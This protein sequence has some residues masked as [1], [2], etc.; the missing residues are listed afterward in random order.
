MSQSVPNYFLFSLYYT[1]TLWFVLC[2][3][4]I[5]HRLILP[6]VVSN[7]IEIVPVESRR[8][9]CCS[10]PSIKREGIS[11]FFGIIG[12][13]HNRFI[14]F[15]S[16][17]LPPATPTR[18]AH[19]L[20]YKKESSCG[21]TYFSRKLVRKRTMKKA[22]RKQQENSRYK[23]KN[24]GGIDYEKKNLQKVRG[25]TEESNSRKRYVTP[26]PE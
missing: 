22:E 13:W 16:I 2:C 8:L 7:F 19:S 23:Y 9:T 14:P 17:L 15:L 12:S 20:L 10:S 1:S 26:K 21:C 25:S 3:M 6:S 4:L 18:K 5:A 24:T 11:L